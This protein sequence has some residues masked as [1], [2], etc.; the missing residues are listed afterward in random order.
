MAKH[1]RVKQ[2][3]SWDDVED[4][5]ARIVT[6][7]KR[8]PDEHKIAAAERIAFMAALWAG[9]TDAEMLGILEIAKHELLQVT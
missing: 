8:L 2:V 4:E 9:A 7:L 1:K 3:A 5:V 6:L